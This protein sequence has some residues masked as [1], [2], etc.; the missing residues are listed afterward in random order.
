MFSTAIKCDIS[1]SNEHIRTR[2]YM[3]YCNHYFK[4]PGVLQHRATPPG[5]HDRKGTHKEL[6]MIYDCIII[7]A[8]ASG[9]F[10]GASMSRPVRGLILEKTSRPGT[11]L[12]MS[13][14]GQCNITHAGSIKDF[15]DCYGKHGGRIRKC[16]YRY[17]NTSLAEFMESGG[18]PA[19]TREDGK[20]FPASMDARSVLD[21]LLRRSRECGFS[22]E[23]DS[24]A[25][26]IEKAAHGWTVLSS[27]RR[28]DTRTLVIAT[29]GCSYPRTGSDGSIFRILERDLELKC[30]ELKPALSSVQIKD[31]P[32]G[33]LSGISFKN[34]AVSIFKNGR[35]EAANS[36]GLLFTHNDLSGPAVLNISKYSAPGDTIQISYLYPLDRDTVLS[37]LKK[38]D[39]QS[40]SRLSNVIAD[41]FGLPKRFCQLLTARYGE[42]LKKLAAQLTGE[43]FEIISV[44]GFSKAMCTSGGVD[45]SCIDLSTMQ[46][47]K[48]PGI[49]VIGEALDID[50]I[51]GGY[52]LQF[53]YSSACAAADN[54]AQTV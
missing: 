33:E 1:A 14:S 41:E 17:S 26:K 23:Y 5:I 11:K 12:L 19:V 21:M 24:P 40:S 32:Y 51:T 25:E 13:G 36:G 34:A 10:C 18:V 20:V 49:Y 52:N 15:I 50:G 29:G 22:I 28:F 45:L 2:S 35:K 44:S 4:A 54:I 38:A 46:A 43:I 6:M 9:L 53:A 48:L 27:G 16:L 31:Y 47:K 7:G 3:V 42:S 39:H 37:R 8:G 30:T